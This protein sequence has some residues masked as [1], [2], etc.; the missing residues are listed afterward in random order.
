[1]HPNK[2]CS[3]DGQPFQQGDFFGT[4]GEIDVLSHQQSGL[5]DQTWQGI[6]Y[7]LRK[8]SAGKGAR[9][10]E[11]AGLEDGIIADRVYGKPVM[12]T[13]FYYEAPPPKQTTK[14]WGKMID[15][16]TMRRLAWRIVIGGAAGLAAGFSGT[17]RG[18]PVRLN[19][20]DAGGTK[21]LKLLSKE[22]SALSPW[23]LA[24]RNELTDDWNLCM[25]NPGQR[26]VC[27]APRGGEVKLDLSN[28]GSTYTIEWLNPRTGERTGGGIITGGE[29]RAFTPPD[30][31]VELLPF[32]DDWVLY[33]RKELAHEGQENIETSRAL[34]L[35]SGA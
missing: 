14:G 27:Y 15:A 3:S 1:V 29:V 5:A 2:S 21:Y 24:P 30:G 33:L 17:W 32:G 6:F 28:D 22:L 4:A 20:T 8:P 19:L 11:G 16:H 26:Y 9:Q 34:H 18:D 35:L 7:P 23:A 25:A 12:V 31:R 10:L 13:E